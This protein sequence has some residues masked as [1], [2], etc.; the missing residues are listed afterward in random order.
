MFPKAPKFPKG[1]FFFFP[2]RKIFTFKKLE[3]EIYFLLSL[4]DSKK[5]ERI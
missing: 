1:F 5:S 4:S 3:S 2:N